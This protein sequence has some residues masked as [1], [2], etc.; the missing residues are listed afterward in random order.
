MKTILINYYQHFLRTTNIV[1]LHFI[2]AGP[3]IGGGPP[4]SCEIPGPE[5]QLHPHLT[6]C[7]LFGYLSKLFDKNLKSFGTDAPFNFS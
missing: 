1:S 7:S 2:F 6:F 3:P 4:L 5:I